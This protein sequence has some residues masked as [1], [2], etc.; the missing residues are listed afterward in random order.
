MIVQ[1]RWASSTV[2][3]LM[4]TTILVGGLGAV[5][6]MLRREFGDDLNEM[7][8][9][10]LRLDAG[11]SD[12]LAP[13]ETERELL[14][15]ASVVVLAVPEAVAVEALSTVLPLLR[16]DALLVET[17]SVKSRF[18]AE[19]TRTRPRSEVLG[20]NPMF[21]PSLKIPGRAVGVVPYVPG[22]QGERFVSMLTARNVR[23]TE[24]AP[25]A[26]DQVAAALQALPHVLVLAFSRVLAMLDLNTASTLELTPP[27]A[28]AL[29]ALA[30]RIAGGSP[31][32]YSDIQTGNPYA[33][34]ARDMLGDAVAEVLEASADPAEFDALLRQVRGDL[35]CG[36]VGLQS[37]G[38]SLVQ[39]QRPVEV[40]K[41]ASKVTSNG[42]PR[43]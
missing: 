41:D 10:D 6:Q 19:L 28:S 8:D 31:H 35:E 39:D 29:L 22:T 43:R 23:I 34:S 1:N 15:R 4:G 7:V 16:S 33:Q 40:A 12:I 21:G 17:L 25:E 13:N 9:M 27:P 36:M 38:E 42:L 20:I 37:A 18:G 14:K 11:P 26:H 2:A 3:P 32:V 24:L 5:G 30:A